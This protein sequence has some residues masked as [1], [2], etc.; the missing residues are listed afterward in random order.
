MAIDESTPLLENSQA[1]TKTPLPKIR[2]GLTLF[3]LFSE[4]MSSQC[5]FPFINQL[6]SPAN[7]M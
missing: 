6:L 1:K 7:I 3:V 4:P 2:L 5:I